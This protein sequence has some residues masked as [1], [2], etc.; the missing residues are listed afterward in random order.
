M[1]YSEKAVEWPRPS[2]L[3]RKERGSRF[4]IRGDS[5]RCAGVQL[6]SC[7]GVQVCRC[8]GWCAWPEVFV[9]NVACSQPNKAGREVRGEW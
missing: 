9:N 1:G 4:E 8:A 5:G 6:C 2:L 7:A 3:G